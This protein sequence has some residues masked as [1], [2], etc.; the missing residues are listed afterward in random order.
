M[1][2]AAGFLAGSI[3]AKL[4]LD[5]GD[6]KKNL[7]AVKKDE[8][9]FK[10]AASKI[11]SSLA[12]G[13]KVAA[14]AVAAAVGTFGLLTKK[15]ADA[16]DAFN[17]MSKR[18]GISVE[19]LSAY[20]L[21]A[22]KTGTSIEGMAVGFRGLSSRML[23]ASRG[24]EAQKQTFDEL[25]IKVTGADGR[26]RSM[27]DVLLDVADRFSKMEDGTRK[28]AL[29]QDL[30]G[31]S[32]MELIPMLN[33][34]RAAILKNIDAARRL[35]LVWS[36]EDAQAADLF[37]DSLAELQ[38]SFRGIGNDVGKVLIPVF[39]TLVQAATEGIANIRKHIADL[40]KSGQLRE[41]A[42]AAAKGFITAFKWMG[43]A[44]E[45][46]II[47][48]PSLKAAIFEV[49]NYF[50]KTIS[51]I[52]DAWSKLP[53]TGAAQSLGLTVLASDFEKLASTYHGAAEENVAFA[54]G[55]VA[56]FDKFFIELDKIKEKVGETPKAVA[57]FHAAVQAY[58]P[59][60][61]ELF[62]QLATKAGEAADS[63]YSVFG[64]L[65]KVIG[66]PAFAHPWQAPDFDW[67]ADLQEQFD[68]IKAKNEEWAKGTKKTTDE[69]S[70][71]F[72]GLY[73]DIAQGFASA[74]EGLFD[75]TKSFAD[76]F[77]S[78]WNSIKQAFFRVLGEMVAGFLVKFVKKIVGGMGLVEA[79]TSAVGIGKAVTSAATTAATAAASAAAT[80]TA[81]ATVASSAAS[82]LSGFVAVGAFWLSSLTSLMRKNLDPK[83]MPMIPLMAIYGPGGYVGGTDMPT[84]SGK[85]RHTPAAAG[86]GASAGTGSSGVTFNISTLDGADVV[87]VVRQ[88]VI[89][90][91]REAAR[92]REFWIP[93]GSAG[94]V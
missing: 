17:D 34:G 29:A 46:L 31:R 61:I 35:G 4:L 78:I 3:V 36:K 66:E 82:A 50:Y 20:E 38:G 8:L 72:D 51:W 12:L 47:L 33:E 10:N 11:G 81:A 90:I 54:S 1:T 93:L 63:I 43:K 68:L 18:V 86:S 9:T 6:W 19:D 67:D 23:D 41:W 85:Y 80:S 14:G 21:L 83:A 77:K 87:R 76:F 24:L 2:G 42:V 37:N 16:G 22:K 39:T 57:D 71:Y 65:G 13:V 49:A 64:S 60:D 88:R 91:L 7:Q 55:I 56:S 53:G 59:K 75:G 28:A 27:N 94:G 15:V 79:L 40:A 58:I 70:H 74:M 48:F 69:V 44:V 45:G 25:G 32:G 52:L 89:P 62:G 73:N 92:R 5:T 26:L 84:W 30:F